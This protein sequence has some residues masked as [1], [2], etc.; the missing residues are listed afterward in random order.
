MKL[1]HV[2][3]LESNPAARRELIEQ[4]ARAV[5]VPRHID[6]DL[7]YSYQIA[8]TIRPFIKDYI[9]EVVRRD[10]GDSVLAPGRLE[11]ALRKEIGAFLP[12]ARGELQKS[13][14]SPQEL[15]TRAKNL[16]ELSG[17]RKLAFANNVTRTLSTTMGS[18]W[19]R[20][21]DISP[22]G[23]SPEIEFEIAMKGI[24]VVL[25]NKGTGEI[26]FAQLKTQQNTLT[27]SQKPRSVKEL[28]IHEN[29]IFCACFNT[30]SN[31]TF[32]KHKAIPRVA[33]AGFWSRIG[34][35]YGM[36]L[37]NVKWMI[38]ELED[39]YVRILN[40]IEDDQ[41]MSTQPFPGLV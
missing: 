6:A 30:N 21:A 23:L 25:M 10:A 1:N 24:D 36:V 40:S 4:A 31:W 9:K 18:L 37:E 41:G 11:E 22:Y 3:L 33:G 17:A 2:E 39:E 7:E 5:V 14:P 28:I 34:I 27:G 19:E 32:G 8:E 12:M 13:V 35:D 20:L 26:E 38:G 16:Y 29:P 15:K